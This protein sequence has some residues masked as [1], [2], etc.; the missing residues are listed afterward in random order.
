[1]TSVTF[2]HMF[3]NKNVTVLDRTT[4]KAIIHG[5]AA[6]DK[7]GPAVPA[8]FILLEGIKEPI[9]VQ[10]TEDEILTKLGLKKEK[11]NE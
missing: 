4:C 11:T 1:M 6:S 3:S 2:T 7:Q 8:T 5:F 9:P 10:E